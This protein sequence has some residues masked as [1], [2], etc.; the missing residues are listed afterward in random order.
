M[1]KFLRFNDHKS[2]HISNIRW[3]AIV[4]SR[5]F[6]TDDIPIFELHSVY[7]PKTQE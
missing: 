1:R 3:F 5:D 4:E 7:I 6:D 2:P